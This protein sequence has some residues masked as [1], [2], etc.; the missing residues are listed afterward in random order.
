[1]RA[2]RRSSSPGQFQEWNT[3][4][5]TPTSVPPAIAATAERHGLTILSRNLKHFES[6][7]VPAIDPFAAYISS[8]CSLVGGLP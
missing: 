5:T 8:G 6:L 1:M 7:G 2:A 4:P 3:P